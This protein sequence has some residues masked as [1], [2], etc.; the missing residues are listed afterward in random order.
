MRDLD[1]AMAIK[2]LQVKHSRALDAQVW[3]GST[4]EALYA[5]IFSKLE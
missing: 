2:H 1:G 3:P 5:Y 4:E